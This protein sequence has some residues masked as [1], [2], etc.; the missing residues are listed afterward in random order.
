MLDIEK[1]KQDREQAFTIWFEK[2]WKRV[3]LEK[4][5]EKSNQE[6][7]TS[8]DI[9]FGNYNANEKR[10]MC[11]RVF[12]L[13]LQDMLPGFAVDFKYSK[14]IFTESEYLCGIRINWEVCESED[15]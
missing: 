11:K 3:G 14:N 2:W 1:L 15:I 9:V 7:F 13:K 6:G 5:I 8:L 4:K 10:W 12:L